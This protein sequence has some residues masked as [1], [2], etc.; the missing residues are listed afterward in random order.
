MMQRRTAAASMSHGRRTQAA[1]VVA[2]SQAVK[3]PPTKINDLGYDACTRGWFDV[4]GQGVCNDYCA[5]VGLGCG[6]TTNGYGSS[7]NFACVL[8]GTTHGYG[9]VDGGTALVDFRMYE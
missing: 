1:A 9:Y 5:W 7:G 8:A 2:Q 6:G 3:S 4:S